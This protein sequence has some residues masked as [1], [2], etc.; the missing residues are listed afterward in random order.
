M[1]S[2]KLVKIFDLNN[3]LIGRGYLLN[4]S[5]ETIMVKG[6][7]LPVLS[8]GTEIIIEI[9]NEFSGISQYFCHVNIASVNQLN[10]LVVRKKIDF[11]RRNFLKV[12]TDLSFYVES[13]YRSGENVT[14]D[15]SN[16]KI[17]ILNLSIGGMLISSNYELFVNDV[18]SFDFHYEN[19]PL[20]LLKAM[21]IRIDTIYDN[22]TKQLS[23]RNYGCI[24]E[25]MPS[26]YE[27][28]ITKYLYIRQL[29]LF[30]NI[31]E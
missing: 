16:M 10:A 20:I 23:I 19:S 27:D 2:D 24:F 8:S 1:I 14:K 5:S 25:Q 13:I 7:K 17:N 9:Y 21:V 22:N 4:L 26:L 28:M 12:R 3:N 11:E 15:F 18:L 31:E 30:K 29:Q 6:T